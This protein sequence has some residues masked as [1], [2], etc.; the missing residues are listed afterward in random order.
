MWSRARYAA[1]EDVAINEGCLSRFKKRLCHTYA[2]QQSKPTKC[3]H[4][5][6][7]FQRT[8]MSGP[9]RQF[10]PKAVNDKHELN[11]YHEMKWWRETKGSPC[12]LYLK[13]INHTHQTNNHHTRNIRCSCRV[14]SV[15][16]PLSASPNARASMSPTWQPDYIKHNNT[17]H[18]ENSRLFYGL[19]WNVKMCTCVCSRLCIM[20][21][22]W[23][24]AI[25]NRQ[26]QTGTLRTTNSLEGN[27]FCEISHHQHKSAWCLKGIWDIKQVDVINIQPRQAEA[28]RYL[29]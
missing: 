29:E 23:W 9:A 16:F 26:S 5:H 20:R 19:I 15:V 24:I 2:T 21:V 25:Q 12:A 6:L 17:I 4:N 8:N 14:V 13:S 1:A 7:T 27:L 28:K 3:F 18:N 11:P 10:A 22:E